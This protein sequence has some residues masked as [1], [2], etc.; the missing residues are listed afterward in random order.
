MGKVGRPKKKEEDKKVKFGISIEKYLFDRLSS[1]PIS[2][3]KLI[4]KLIKEYYGKK[5]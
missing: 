1:E 2:K 5:I 3:S 4:S